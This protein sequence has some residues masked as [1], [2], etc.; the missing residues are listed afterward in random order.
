MKYGFVGLCS[1]THA[2]NWI[3]L[4]GVNASALSG[5]YVLCCWG[6]KVTAE[7]HLVSSV[8]LPNVHKSGWQRLP[9]RWEGKAEQ[10]WSYWGWSCRGFFHVRLPTPWL[11]DPSLFLFLF[12]FFLTLAR[13]DG[14][15]FGFCSEQKP[16]SKGTHASSHF[17][18]HFSL[19][20]FLCD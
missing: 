16:R 8:F 4:V 10:G 6:D 17:F 20:Y 2:W 1:G 11:Q 15:Q 12:L 14:L 5:G 3:F 13:E 19:F 18:P 7:G 9:R